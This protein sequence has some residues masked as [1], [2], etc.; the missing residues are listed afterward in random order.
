MFGLDFAFLLASMVV[1]LLIGLALIGFGLI[2]RNRTR[3]FQYLL[4]NRSGRSL[5][6]I[7]NSRSSL[8]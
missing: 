7:R 3:N 1:Y 5:A 2:E 6:D 8:S 4:R